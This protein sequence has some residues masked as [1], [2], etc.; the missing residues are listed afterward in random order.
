MKARSKLITT[1]VIIVIVGLAIWG[2]IALAKGGGG[3]WAG[4]DESVI[5]KFAHEAGREARAPFINT[6]QGDLLLFVF[7]LGAGSAG[8]I[9]GYFWRT[10]ISGK[11]E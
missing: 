7:A 5:E 3:G 6:D 10:L 4:T 9:G 2:S 8:F 11:G 1:L